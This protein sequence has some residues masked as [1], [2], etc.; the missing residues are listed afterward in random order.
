MALKDMTSSLRLDRKTAIRF[1]RFLVVGFVNMLFGYSVF[2]V[3]IL[4]GMGPELALALSFA[5]GVLWNYVT[6]ARFVFQVQCYGRF[7]GFAATYIGVYFAN[8][9]CLNAMIDAGFSSLVSQ[10]ILTPPASVL[11][12]GLL[13][14]VMRESPKD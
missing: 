5:S 12:F 1:G 7:P 10:A 4:L 9:F 8:V 14:L 3:L 11:T 6:T 2:A 13:S